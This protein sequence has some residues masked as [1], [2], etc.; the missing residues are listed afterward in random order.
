MSSRLLIALCFVC[1]VVLLSSGCASI[2]SGKNQPLSVQ[3]TCA[4]EQIIG[5]DCTLTN[6]KGQWFVQ[7]P[8]SLVIQKSYGDLAVECRKEGLAPTTGTFSSRSNGGVW[9]NLIA[10]GLIG[11]AVDASSGAGFDY[12][13]QLTVLFQPPCPGADAGGTVASP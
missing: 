4:G 12:P 11:Y 10:G 3:S 5:A 9:G 2:T 8:G 7:T 1:P 6:N 13:T